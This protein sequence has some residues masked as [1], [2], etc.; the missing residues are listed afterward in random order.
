MCFKTLTAATKACLQSA[1][2]LDSLS[3]QQTKKKKKCTKKEYEDCI[4]GYLGVLQC[5]SGEFG[6]KKQNLK[7]TMRWLLLTWNQPPK[8]MLLYLTKHVKC[9]YGPVVFSPLLSFINLIIS[10]FPVID[11]M[12]PNL[13]NLLPLIIPPRC[14]PWEDNGFGQMYLCP[15]VCS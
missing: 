1:G 5:W 3:Q 10:S 11:L 2:E 12:S 8:L 13:S 4:R 6:T 14:K 7:T 15:C 9:V